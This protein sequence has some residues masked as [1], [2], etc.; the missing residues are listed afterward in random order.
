MLAGFP[1]Q[2]LFLKGP[3]SYNREPEAE[4]R[5]ASTTT[6]PRLY[7]T[8]THQ[9]ARRLRPLCA[10]RGAPPRQNNLTVEVAGR[11]HANLAELS[12]FSL[13]NMSNRSSNNTLDTLNSSIEMRTH[14][15]AAKLSPTNAPVMKACSLAKKPLSVRSL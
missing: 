15:Q 7:H 12:N 8:I 1:V 2:P 5:G 11:D 6:T 10:A 13:G 3:S 9:G 4:R 14:E